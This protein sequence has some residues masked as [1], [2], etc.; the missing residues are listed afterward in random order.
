MLI[1][2][3]DD[4]CEYRGAKDSW[5]LE[6][7]LYKYTDCGAWI[8]LTNDVVTIGSIVEGSGAEFSR[9]FAYPFDSDDLDDWIDELEAL[10][11]GA[12]CEANGDWDEEV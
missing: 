1:T 7:D 4:L 10:V 8:T 3:L 11:D 6:H 9:S 5:E 12:W 2:N